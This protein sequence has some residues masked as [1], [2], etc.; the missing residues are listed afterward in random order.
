MDV[1]ARLGAIRETYVEFFRHNL[2]ELRDKGVDCAA[3]VWV[4]PHVRPGQP[5]MP[6]RIC[7]DILQGGDDQKMIMVTGAAPVASPVQ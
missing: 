3:E 1:V 6:E 5:A 4:E 2:A 7:I